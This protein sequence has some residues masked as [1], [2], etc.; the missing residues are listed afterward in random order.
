MTAPHKLEARRLSAGYD[1]RVILEDIT[2]E[3]RPSQITAI[4]G[5]N[6]SGKSTLLRT[7]ARILPVK[8]GGVFLDGKS[9]HEMPSL[10]VARIMG[11]LPQSPIAPEGITVADL[12]GRGRHPHHGLF[13]RWKREDD[14]A[15]TDAL[16]ATGI[17]VL[18]DRE[19]DTL[20]GGQRQRAWIA[21]AL[22]QRTDL[23]LLDEPTTFLDV[24][25]QIEVLDLLVDMNTT[26]G[27]TIVMVLHDLNLAA[28]YADHL[29]AVADKGIYAEGPPAEILTRDLVK[30]VFGLECHIATDPVA[31]TPLMVP[32]GRHKTQSVL[33]PAK[34]G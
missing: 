28:R 6:A 26:R 5:G 8:G 33:R 29:I 27:T 21:M 14:R 1:K 20:S 23:L 12:V 22:A 2:L 10:G 31:G 15:V 9:I 19:L 24:A 13:S 25:H 3:L 18:A 4:V 7:L 32:V 30:A 17:E 11:L 16:T 34:V